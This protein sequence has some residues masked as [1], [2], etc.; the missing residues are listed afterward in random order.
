MHEPYF[1][2]VQAVINARLPI[3]QSIRA[4]QPDLIRLLD[5]PACG[6]CTDFHMQYALRAIPCDDEQEAKY[7]SGT[8]LF[9]LAALQCGD[10]AE[11]QLILQ[12]ARGVGA[13]GALRTDRLRKAALARPKPLKNVPWYVTHHLRRTQEQLASELRVL[14][15]HLE[16]LDEA[17]NAEGAKA[18]AHHM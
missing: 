2:A 4:A 10:H 16:R 8:L 1:G 13:A 5:S 12:G 9:T 17:L 6:N 15:E 3:K 18:L 11:E 7:R 14:C